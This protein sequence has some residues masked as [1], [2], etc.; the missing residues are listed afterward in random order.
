LT[1]HI[2]SSIIKIVLTGEEEVVKKLTYELREQFS[3]EKHPNRYWFL[4][5]FTPYLIIIALAAACYGFFNED[6]PA[7]FTATGLG[8]VSSLLLYLE[9]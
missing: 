6:A 9:K 3:E 5:F 2:Q 1:K 7:L 8:L 4:F